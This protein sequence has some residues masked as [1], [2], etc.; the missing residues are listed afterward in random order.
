MAKRMLIDATH[1]EETRV[2]VLSGNRLEAFDFETSIKKQI[3]GNIYLA[4]V[5]RVE[6]SLQA[7]FVDYGGNRHGFLAFSEIHPDYYRIPV[8]DRPEVVRETRSAMSREDREVET[9]YGE[10]DNP[11]R[12]DQPDYDDRS[13]EG[14]EGAGEADGHSEDLGGDA[15]AENDG[16][17][18][19]GQ[20]EQRDS[21]HGSLA[22]PSSLLSGPVS[23]A[24]GESD[25]DVAYGGSDDSPVDEDPRER[26]PEEYSPE[27]NPGAADAGD[28]E[29][30]PGGDDSASG[31]GVDTEEVPTSRPDDDAGFERTP[32]DTDQPVGSP[33]TEQA[34]S[35]TRFAADDDRGTL[36]TGDAEPASP[37][38]ADP[39]ATQLIEDG[40]SP[41]APA[42]YQDG[43]E[44]DNEHES[45][46]PDYREEHSSSVEPPNDLH[47]A[48]ELAEEAD[49]ILLAEVAQDHTVVGAGA[50]DRGDDHD[51]Y[52]EDDAEQVETVGG[53]ELEVEDVAHA[54]PRSLRSYKIQ[55]VIKRRQI[56]L[57][58]VTKEE[59]GN[60]GAAL[61]TYLSL[62]GRYCVLM[63]NTDR[64]GGVSRK[65]TNVADRRRLKEVVGEL[66]VPEGIGVIVRTAG[67][68]R[69]KTEIKRDY[70]Y[71][72]RLW[73]DIRE[74][75]LRSQAPAL[76]HEESS[77]IK[78]AI[79]DLYSKEIGEVLVDGEEGYRTA[80]DFMRMLMPGQ[81]KQVQAYR[82]PA[83]PLF[84]RFG[85]DA[86]IDAIHSPVA[87]LKSGG[88]IVINTTEAL[89]AID[90]NSGRST[91]ERN[92]EETA[93]KTNLE[94]ADEVARQ[95][96]LRDLAGLIVIDF[97]DM[98]DGRNRAAVE[99]RLK[100]AM[101]VDRARIQLGRI[102]PFGLLELSRQRLRPSLLEAS[103]QLCP[104]CNG[105]GTIRSVESTALVILRAIEDE[106]IRQRSAEIS[107]AIPNGVALYMLNHKRQALSDIEE[108]YGFT[109]TVIGDDT[110]IPP[111]FRLERLATMSPEQA[112][113][114]RSPQRGFRNGSPAVE[115]EEEIEP[116]VEEAILAEDVEEVSEAVEAAEGKGTLDR[117]S[118]EA[119]DEGGRRRRR[120]RRGRRPDAR[121]AGAMTE[122]ESGAAEFADA[123]D[124]E[125]EDVDEGVLNGQ[126][127]ATGSLGPSALESDAAEAGLD[128]PEGSELAPRVDPDS[129]DESAGRRRRGRRGGRRR[130]R[131]ED[132]AAPADA[133]V[134]EQDFVGGYGPVTDFA[135]DG[136]PYLAVSQDEPE[137]HVLPEGT[138]ESTD[139]QD[140]ALP[141]AFAGTVA[142]G[143]GAE[144]ASAAVEAPQNEEPRYGEPPADESQ[145]VEFQREAPRAEQLQAPTVSPATVVDHSSAAGESE[146]FVN[147]P[148]LADA[149]SEPVHQDAAAFDA[150][151][152]SVSSPDAAD[153]ND[154]PDTPAPAV[155]PHMV[156]Q[157]P[158]N[159]RS[160][161][162]KR[163]LP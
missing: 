6:P 94:A 54:R 70:E 61:T 66:D 125:E 145:V 74:L 63:P 43:I 20:I 144:H 65:I 147:M 101:R 121:V 84:H 29:S 2:A 162:W 9:L 52:E 47:F 37:E 85:V 10:L 139:V 159:P 92:I 48:S 27:D 25:D 13:S 123:D 128:A 19:S 55:E 118:R 90:V 15:F 79:R 137:G 113:A 152:A 45:D 60:K 80:R 115:I 97:I 86:Q 58:Q 138:G 131:R 132:A 107:V 34:F 1:P 119:E 153:E 102:S 146:P 124:E 41:A 4:K 134:P 56:L 44:G 104:H 143:E 49:E 82:D 36:V 76:I 150:G 26:V 95:L 59:R 39:H 136:R 141:S 16:P 50:E 83:V 42:S 130:G 3:K 68:E 69:S 46:F 116:E 21:D 11:D 53:D 106:G 108:R 72:L 126:Q 81:S 149:P 135:N 87:Q 103:T 57:V 7:A 114:L 160:G 98:E 110:L 73:D 51:D 96:R 14:Y 161:W 89:V 75:T 157:K 5:T 67:S 35:A 148:A 120:R 105:T 158:E 62:A 163:L 156:T 100:E 32:G 77:L 112:A 151:Q 88:Y 31:T 28:T 64:G 129:D 38:L 30:V 140:P 91:K 142:D 109:V 127:T 93:T 133:P 71:L 155:I 122:A 12:L 154:S 40:R 99:R 78:R 18:E 33:E 23:R 111:A 117:R 8:G 24:G 17:A 22:L